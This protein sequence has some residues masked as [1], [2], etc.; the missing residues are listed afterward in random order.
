MLQN[1]VNEKY[2][3]DKIKSLVSLMMVLL[4]DA[5]KKYHFVKNLRNYMFTRSINNPTDEQLG[6]L[7]FWRSDPKKTG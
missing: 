1:L 4:P 5:T 2:L 6:E 7:V 3:K